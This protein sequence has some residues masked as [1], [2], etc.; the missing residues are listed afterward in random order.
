MKVIDI[1]NLTCYYFEDI[2]K[3]K[4]FDFNNILLDEKSYVNILVYNIS[5]KILISPKPLLIRFDKVDGFIRVYDGTR[6]LVL[7]GL[8]KYDP[9]TIE[10]WTIIEY[11][12]G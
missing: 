12:I 5:Y 2:I 8:R 1:K 10:Y 6:H 7:F 4:D 3:I 9:F 11:L